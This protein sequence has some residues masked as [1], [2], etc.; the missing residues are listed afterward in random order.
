[1]AASLKSF[2]VCRN[3]LNVYP[4]PVS[5]Q[6]SKTTRSFS[7]ESGEPAVNTSEPF[8]DA[9]FTKEHEELRRSLSKVRKWVQILTIDKID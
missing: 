3:F 7:S 1:M 6:G 9:L 8:Q 2:R 5:C 4:R